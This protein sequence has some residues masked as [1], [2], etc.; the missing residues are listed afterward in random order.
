MKEE[1]KKTGIKKCKQCFKEF[2]I[3][4]RN[5]RSANKIFCSSTCAKKNNGKNNKGKKRSLKY[6]SMM[7]EK[8]SGKNNGFFGKT[9]SK[10][11]VQKMSSSS[12][13]Q[14]D[15]FKY[16]NLKNKE[17]E[18]LDGLML[19]DGCLSEKS[20]ISARLTFGFKF[21][22]TCEEI[23]KTIS[24]LNFSPIWQSEQTKCWHTKSNMYHDLL[25]ENKRWYPQ[26]EKIVPLDVL[27]TK[28]SCYW[29]FIGDG[30]N[31][32]GNVYLHRLLF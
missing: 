8:T 24:S 21:K 22:E 13:W 23:F 9:H 20:R 7:S 28:T 6:K 31:I 19:S 17:K 18:V 1:N 5:K 3:N 2:Q 12:L 29:W 16:C 14:E 27:I 26:K 25:V 11:S 32:D 30:Y 15:K 4:L 10:K